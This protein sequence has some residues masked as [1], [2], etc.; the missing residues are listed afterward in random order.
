MQIKSFL[1]VLM[2]ALLMWAQEPAPPGPGSG[3]PMRSGH[4]QQMMEM[5]KQEMEAL[6]AEIEKMKSSLR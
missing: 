5:H 4:R 3:D 2:F 1:L 6:R